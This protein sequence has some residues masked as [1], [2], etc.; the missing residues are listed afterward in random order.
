LIQFPQPTI[1]LIAALTPPEH[2]VSHTDEIVE[3]LR[4][5]TPAA[6]TSD[7]RPEREPAPLFRAL[8]PLPKWVDELVHS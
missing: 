7:R 3:P 5:D 1:P 8:T 6:S 2:S 4:F